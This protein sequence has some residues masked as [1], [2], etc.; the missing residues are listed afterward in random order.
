MSARITYE[1]PA[2]KI[3]PHNFSCGEILEGNDGEQYTIIDCVF[4]QENQN[5]VAILQ[6][7]DEHERV[8]HH[9]LGGTF[10]F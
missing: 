10:E 8:D 6:L 2:N 7:L 4:V 5:H 3:T 1:V 9:Y